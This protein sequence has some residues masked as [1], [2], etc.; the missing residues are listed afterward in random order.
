MVNRKRAKGRGQGPAKD[1]PKRVTARLKGMKA[2]EM[3][4][5]GATYQ[6]IADQL[7]YADPSGAYGAV[8]RALQATIQEP[9]DK[10]RNLELRRLDGLWLRAWTRFAG[11]DMTAGP[12]CLK[13]ME[14][15][16]RLL[17]LDA[18]VQTR[19]AGHDNGPVQIEERSI[20]SFDSSTLAEAFQALIQAGALESPKEA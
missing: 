3:R 20:I 1:S 8:E 11:G 14:R 16:A 15:R 10:V 6:A 4:A 17:G 5:G 7:G 9:A 19:L 2:L 12:L 13:I 18:P